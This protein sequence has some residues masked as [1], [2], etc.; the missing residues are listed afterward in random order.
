MRDYFYSCAFFVL[1]KGEIY[2]SDVKLLLKNISTTGQLA[3]ALSQLPPDTVIYPFGSDSCRLIYKESEETAYLDED[4]G[5]LS[6][7]DY[8]SLED[9]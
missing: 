6:E 8:E 9:Q 4:F 5:F 7:E 3:K 1:C 2:M